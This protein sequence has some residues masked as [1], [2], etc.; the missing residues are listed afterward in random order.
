M[1][2]VIRATS[3][4]SD[5]QSRKTSPVQSRRWSSCVNAWPGAGSIATQKTRPDMI[6]KFRKLHRSVRMSVP[7]IDRRCG[8]SPAIRR[9]ES[10][11]DRM[12][13][14]VGTSSSLNGCALEF[15]MML[16]FR[17]HLVVP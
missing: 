3:G 11:H 16:H 13:T 8:R 12:E 2:A 10:F 1:Q 7:P 14:S 9:L 6:L 4:I 15:L 5:E 17:F